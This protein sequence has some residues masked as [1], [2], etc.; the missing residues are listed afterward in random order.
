MASSVEILVK[1]RDITARAFSSAVAGA[2][3][4]GA[5]IGRGLQAGIAG[6]KR[7]AIG[8]GAAGAA[9]FAVGGKLVGMYQQD[10]AAQAKMTAALRASGFAAG[11][12]ATELKAEASRLQE[13]TGV[14]DD[15]ILSTQGL[16][17]AFSNVRGDNFK[18]ATVAA[19]DMGAWLQ[20]A[21]TD[22]AGV[23]DAMLALGRALDNPAQNMTLLTS[24][25]I[26]FT[27]A[28]KKR[29]VELQKSGRLAE[30]QAIIL[31]KLAGKFGGVAEEVN[32]SSHGIKGLKNALG[33]AGE[34]IGQ[35]IVESEHFDGVIAKITAA[36]KSLS[37]S[38]YIELWAENIRNGI[39]SIMPL[40]SK[41]GEGFGWIKSKIQESAA[42]WGGVAGAQ[43]GLG[44]RFRAGVEEMRAAP[45][46]E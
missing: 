33:D 14:A 43:G 26:A 1:A 30:A 46:P 39:A 17:A 19:I 12:T 32:K 28:E 45:P 31:D 40:L 42:F 7:L 11:F 35:A 41:V 2:K 24:R 3:R 21:G 27:E 29:I 5:A 20:K 25:G 4:M 44:A 34:A 8:V 13:L 38:G 18:R 36:V 16:L 6:L 10:A 22:A 23:E 37:E 9:M 15:A